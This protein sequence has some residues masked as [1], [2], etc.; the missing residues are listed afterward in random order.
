MFHVE[1]GECGHSEGKG[2]CHVDALLRQA[3]LSPQC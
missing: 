2:M 3:M 1:T